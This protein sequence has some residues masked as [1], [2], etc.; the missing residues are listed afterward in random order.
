MVKEIIPSTISL[1]KKEEKKMEDIQ[2]A[3]KEFTR[4]LS[5][6]GVKDVECR[7]EQ[8][9]LILEQKLGSGIRGLGYDAEEKSLWLCLD[10]LDPDTIE[11]NQKWNANTVLSIENKFQEVKL[12]KIDDS[13]VKIVIS[14]GH[15]V[16]CLAKLLGKENNICLPGQYN[17]WQRSHDQAFTLDEETGDLE[18]VIKWNGS[19]IEC[20]V[21]I[22]DMPCD[23][24]SGKWKQNASQK[25]E[26]ELS[27]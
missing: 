14:S 7:M 4:S 16:V 19:Q 10:Q 15:P 12:E 21:A 1:N 13:T 22:K 9:K 5:E 25:L 20:K 11:E 27:E 2:E 8:G 3:F 24:Q 18:N 17:N 6:H 23:W 26:A